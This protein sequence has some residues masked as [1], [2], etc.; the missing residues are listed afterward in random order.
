MN[1]VHDLGGMH[2]FGPVEHE[3]DEPVFHAEWERTAFALT[4]AMGAWGRWNL[5]MA[6]HSRERMPPHAYLAAGY[7]ERWLWGLATLLVEHGF[8]S[9]E[10]LDR[11]AERPRT[12]RPLE[13]PEPPLV[14]ARPE[15]VGRRHPLP[16]GA[17][18]I[19]VPP[20]PGAHGQGEG[21]GP[22]LP[23]GVEHR[24]ILLPDDW[25]EAGPPAHVVDAVHRAA[26]ARAAG[27]SGAW[28][29][30]VPIMASRV[31]RAASSS[32]SI[33]S[34]PGGRSGRTR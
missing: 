29:L 32:S 25:S 14:V 1:G 5:D 27:R 24:L 16:P 3:A 31:T 9:R 8:L 2:G 19:E 22:P 6:R 20:P 10:E 28:T 18:Y 34:V 11:R 7:Y 23:L 15:V 33:P 13:R 4:L 30:A 17:R 21:E 12:A 26:S